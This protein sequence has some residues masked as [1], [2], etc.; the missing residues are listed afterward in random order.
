MKMSNASVG[1]EMT[2][3]KDERLSVRELERNLI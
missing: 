1:L 2:S 3:N